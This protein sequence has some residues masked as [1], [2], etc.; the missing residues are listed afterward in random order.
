MCW[1]GKKDWS[2]QLQY[3]ERT[4]E[5]ETL[6]GFLFQM[7]LLKCSPSI[8]AGFHPRDGPSSGSLGHAMPRD[9]AYLC[10]PLQNIPYH[11]H[12]FEVHGGVKWLRGQ[13]SDRKGFKEIY[14][15]Y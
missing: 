11:P 13:V 12:V 4:C 7:L 14:S 15:L 1:K 3:Q 8:L 10:L 5:N 2:S 9:A 6:F